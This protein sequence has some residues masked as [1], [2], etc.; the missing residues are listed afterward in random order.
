MLWEPLLH[1]E[2]AGE[3][4]RAVRKIAVA[5]AAAPE[6]APAA[7]RTMFWAYACAEI[8]D[9]DAS[10]AYEASLGDLVAELE[11]GVAH[12]ALY[13]GLC[14]IGW[15]LAHVMDDGADEPLA[16][17]DEALLELL[18]APRWSGAYDLT[19]GLVG[20]GVYFLERLATS[21][22]LPREGL[23]RVVRQLAALAE[24]AAGGVTWHTR[25]ET[26]PAFVTADFPDGFYDCGV[27]HG[28]PGTIALLARIAELA[29]PPPEARALCD[30]AV[31]W[32]GA[33]RG[34]ADPRG[35]FPTRMAPGDAPGRSRAAWC[36]GDPGVAA[37]LW[38]AAPELAHETALECARRDAETCGVVDAGLC[39]G[40]AGLA[41]LFNRFYQASG[42]AAFAG[43]ARA[44]FARALAMQR[45]LDGF[46]GFTAWFPA[47]GGA[48]AAHRPI[49]NFLEGSIGIGLALLAA[50]APSVPNWD[51][52]L[53]CDLPTRSVDAHVE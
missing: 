11:R 13:G 44:W 23:A 46:G 48:A 4:A 6:A 40:A 45:P 36:Y 10:A 50:T 30:A 29:E 8:D 38:R 47:I 28:A 24:P 21:Q 34:T 33:Q 32:V 17:I 25:A 49:A 2:L 53:L 37:A 3:A 14:G 22:A 12:P 18:A 5:L 51:R 16:V 27:A 15:T 19:Q 43:A 1:G 41:H 26:L 52:L 35:R 7:D 20:I 39:H 9:V 42:D 31:C